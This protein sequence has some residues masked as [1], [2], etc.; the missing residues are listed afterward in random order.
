[1]HFTNYSYK[2]GTLYFYLFQNN[3]NSLN[4]RVYITLEFMLI[5]IWTVIGNFSILISNTLFEIC[6][7]ESEPFQSKQILLNMK[8][9]LK[10]ATSL[11]CKVYSEHEVKPMW[12]MSYSLALEMVLTQSNTVYCFISLSQI[13]FIRCFV[14]I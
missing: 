13:N 5:F 12:I 1:L 3:L 8:I 4:C 2:L 9:S 14:C 10:Q 11:Y 6:I 7:S